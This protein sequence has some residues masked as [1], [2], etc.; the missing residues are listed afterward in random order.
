MTRLVDSAWGNEL[1]AALRL[2]TEVRL[3]CPFLKLPVARRILANR[4]SAIQLITR[5]NLDDFAQ[6]VSDLEA[7]RVLLNSGA[8]IRG[9][10]RLHA[11]V[12]VFGHQ[13]AIVT[14]A[15][16]TNSGLAGNHEFGVVSEEPSVVS[17]ANDYFESLWERAGSDLDPNA[18]AQWRISVAERRSAARPDLPSLG[19]FGAELGFQDAGSPLPARA[20]V[21]APKGF[22]KFLGKSDDRAPLNR[23]IVEEIS[24]SACHWALTY[25][26]SK[27]PRSV[28]AGSLMFISRLTSDKDIIIFG[29]A[30][31][32]A[33]IP[34]RDDASAAE[35]LERPWKS[36]WSRYVR[37][38]GAEFMAGTMAEGVRL[39]DLMTALGSNAFASTQRNATAGR[40][41]LNPRAAYNQ[42]P[43]VELS[44][45]GI[46]W[47]SE[48]L[49]QSFRRNGRV[50]ASTLDKIGWPASL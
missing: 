32:Q 27:K 22:V 8:R 44:R 13:R 3:V 38:H 50:P 48:R 42:Q 39:S 16:L 36:D 47:L 37:V 15:N 34:G 9:V 43:S 35:I 49:D 1:D 2:D 40:G 6:G 28:V 7:L 41:N 25:P 11:K 26:T 33:Y 12:Y 14:S 31:G 20:F 23:E 18:I 45:E 24:R 4:P 19:D 21:D 10:R 46:A 30:I 5:F 17:A 29:R